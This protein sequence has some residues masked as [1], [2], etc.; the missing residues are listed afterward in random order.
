MVY[1]R[2]L[3]INLNGVSYSYRVEGSGQT[4]LLLHGFTGCKENW[5]N[6]VSSLS[7]S[8]KVI[9]LDLVGHGNT[10]SPEE[11]D[12]YEI[13]N[14]CKDIAD[15]LHKLAINRVYLLG[16]SMGGR[17]ALAFTILY[18][19]LVH[20]LILESSSPGLESAEERKKR[21]E[22]DEFLALEIEQMGVP[23]FVEK[24]ESIPLFET[25]KK[26][27]LE[28]REAIRTQRLQNNP[29]GLANSLRGMG[30][31]KQPSY[32]DKLSTIKIPVLFICGEW[33]EKFCGIAE[34]MKKMT[35]KSSIYKVFNAGHAIHVE[36]QDFFGKIV[37]EFFQ[38]EKGG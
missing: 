35:Q 7:T 14:V 11:V 2:D 36:Q 15:L 32:W 27:P 34:K 38:S 1:S 3:E 20:S 29:T 21:R 33:D 37:M 4:V 26:L 12:Q 23:T 18:P 22:A 24:W 31:G 6:L 5:T 8:F 10:D 25:Q 16:Y 13:E 28:T 19:E 9:T 30:T 17:V